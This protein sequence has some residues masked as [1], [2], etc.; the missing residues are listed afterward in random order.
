MADSTVRSIVIGAPSKLVMD[1]IADFDRYP[2]W[3]AAAKTVEVVEAGSDS[4]AKLVRF[5]LD[6]GVFKESYDLVY[7]WAGDGKSVS[8][9]LVRG[10]LQ[11]AQ[12]GSYTLVDKPNGCTEVTYELSVDL[13]IPMIGAFKRKAE[14]V[15]TDTAL[16]ELKKRV[17]G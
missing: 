3:V 15:I 10:D 16:K 12:H 11:K 14:K 1:V 5:V 2:A 7:D 8:W 6:A 13:N 9:E 4:R 17:E